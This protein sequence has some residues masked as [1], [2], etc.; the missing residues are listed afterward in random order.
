MGVDEVGIR[1]G[2]LVDDIVYWQSFRHPVGSIPW[3]ERECSREPVW[4][5]VEGVITSGGKLP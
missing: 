1:E 4:V 5:R 2:S 3:N